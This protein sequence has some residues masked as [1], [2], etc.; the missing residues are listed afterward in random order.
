MGLSG[1]FEETCE[2]QEML[3]GIDC[4]VMPCD[5]EL[6]CEHGE[7]I[8]ITS[9]F[10]NRPYLTRTIRRILNM[11]LIEKFRGNSEHSQYHCTLG[12]LA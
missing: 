11:N 12:R 4:I 10:E 7:P 9:I 5:Y 3:H 6:K 8:S 1:L 2:P